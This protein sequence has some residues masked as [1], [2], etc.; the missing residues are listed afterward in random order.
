LPHI[1]YFFA[2]MSPFTYLAGTRLEDLAARHGATI[3]Y[4]PLDLGAL[5]LRTGGTPLPERHPNRL[6]YR[7]QDLRRLSEKTG[8][9]L[10]L[11]PAFWPV[12]GAPAAYAVIA[13]MDTIAG[14]YFPRG[15]MRAVPDAMA[16]AASA[17]GVEFAYGATATALEWSGSRVTAVRT[18]DGRRHLADAVVLTTELPDT[19]RLLGKTPRRLLRRSP[20]RCA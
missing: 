19:Y 16:A 14:V 13:Y 9:P 11:K 2:T 10:N 20:L 12:N 5:F 18:S 1:D 15:G 17:A 8:L 3:T 6:A 7:L 4:K